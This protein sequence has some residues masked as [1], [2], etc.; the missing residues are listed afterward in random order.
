M[1]LNLGLTP[2]AVWKA[3]QEVIPLANSSKGWKTVFSFEIE[4][5]AFAA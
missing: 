2:E 3:S 1:E 4:V 5:L